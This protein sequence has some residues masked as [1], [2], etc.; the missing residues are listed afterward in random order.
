MKTAEAIGRIREHMRVHKMG[1]YPHVLI[2]DALDMAIHALEEQKRREW[3]PLKMRKP[4]ESG[5]YIVTTCDEGCPAGEGIWY[6][7]VVVEAEFY[8]G[9]WTW[10][11]R[12]T[13]YDITDIVTHWMCM[14]D[15]PKHEY[16]ATYDIESIDSCNQCALDALGEQ[17]EDLESLLKKAL[18]TYL[19]YKQYTEDEKKT[20]EVHELTIDELP[21]LFHGG[22]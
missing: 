6:R 7:T 10:Y 13:E 3:V 2:K 1:Q 15:P 12:G 9:C 16:A 8:K 4:T 11:D 18:Q 17:L 5:L 21:G 20:R 22:T 19:S 14:P